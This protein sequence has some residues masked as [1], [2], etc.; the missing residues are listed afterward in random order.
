MQDLGKLFRAS[1]L[2]VKDLLRQLQEEEEKAQK[3]SHMKRDVDL[4]TSQLERRE[5]QI[6]DLE[7][8]L[9]QVQCCECHRQLPIKQVCA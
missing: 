2:K 1:W 3:L 7:S 6:K 5:Q 9:S 4:M 8:T